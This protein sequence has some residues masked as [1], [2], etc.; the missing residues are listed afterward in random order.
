[1]PNVGSTVVGTGSLSAPCTVHC[2]CLLG[3]KYRSSRTWPRNALPELPEAES[4]ENG[5]MVGS[6]GLNTSNCRPAANR[7]SSFRTS[8]NASIG[9]KPYLSASTLSL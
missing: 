3:L 5:R 7:Q 6:S 2:T 9:R 4:A 8:P 1:M